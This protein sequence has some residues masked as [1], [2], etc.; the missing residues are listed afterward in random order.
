[1]AYQHW[2]PDSDEFWEQELGALKPL[3]TQKLQPVSMGL[4][5][6]QLVGLLPT[7]SGHSLR[8]N[9]RWL[10]KTVISPGT[11]LT[12]EEKVIAE[13]RFSTRELALG[14]CCIAWLTAAIKR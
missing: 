14:V 5:R 1:M 8:I 11:Q 2:L 4:P 6:H 13:L 10:R 9:V 7:R 3:E 12:T